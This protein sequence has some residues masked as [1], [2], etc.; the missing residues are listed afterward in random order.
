MAEKLLQTEGR[1]TAESPEVKAEMAKFPDINPDVAIGNIMQRQRQDAAAQRDEDTAVERPILEDET[2]RQPA[3]EGFMYL[4]G[5]LVEKTSAQNPYSPGSAAAIAWEQQN[6]PTASAATGLTTG[7]EGLEAPSEQDIRQEQIARAQS[8]I[9]AT[10]ALFQADVADLQQQGAEALAGTSSILVGAGLAGS[11]FQLTGETKTKE[12][13][14][15]QVELRRQERS[16]EIASLTAQAENRAD[17]VYQAKIAEFQAERAFLVSERDKEAADASARAEAAKSAAFS[18]I[19]SLASGG[20]SLDE[21]G[22]A[23]YSKLLSDAGI[24]DFE[25]RARWASNVPEANANYSVQG[26]FVVGSYFDPATGKPVVTTTPLPQELIGDTT[27]DIQTLKDAQG[28]IFWYDANNPTN[29]DG[30]LRSFALGEGV[31]DEGDEPLSVSEA[32]ALGVPFGTTRAEAAAMGKV[33]GAEAEAVKLTAQQDAA[34]SALE[35]KV[36]LIDDLLVSEGLAGVVGEFGITRWT[37]FQLDKAERVDFFAGVQQLISQ[38]TLDTLTELKAAGGTLGAISQSELDILQSAATKINTWIMKDDEGVPTGK[39][40]IS[41]ELFEEELNKIRESAASIIDA[42]KETSV[43]DD[44]DTFLDSFNLDLST[45]VNG[46]GASQVLA[47]GSVTGYGSPLWKHG[48][49]IDLKIGD[50]VANVE[51]GEVVF[52]GENAGFGNQVKVRTASGEEYWYSHLDSIN[53]KEGDSVS[54]GDAVGRGGNTGDVIPGPQGD[55]SHLD[56]TVQRPDGSY[57][58]PRELEQRLKTMG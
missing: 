37:P 49:D 1:L 22:G 9:D 51:Q 15:K 58:D 26:G 40:E 16:A 36:S 42:S 56:L 50:P 19:E 31:P 5:R 38:E 18:T 46:S 52:V 28:N 57:V 4:D 8:L 55:G 12:A 27:A 33:P 20:F 47:L 43:G 34:V 3:P 14:Q 32:E 30:T 10:E 39:I 44:I 41:E 35:D 7:L 25:A 23:E 24:S 54:A 21:L 11:P 48:L 45:S 29:P 53:V 13:T 6:A 17:A 2:E